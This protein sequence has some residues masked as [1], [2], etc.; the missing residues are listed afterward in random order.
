MSNNTFKESIKAHGLLLVCIFLTM[1][2]L[3]V[4]LLLHYTKSELL[5]LHT[6]WILIAFAP[7]LVAL[8][9]GGYIRKFKGFGIEF[10]A[11]FNRPLSQRDL[12]AAMQNY[13]AIEV[14][15]ATGGLTK[16]LREEIYQLSDEDKR[17]IQRLS[18]RYGSRY[19]ID[20]AGFYFSKLTNLKYI[21]IQ[22]PQGNFYALLPIKS[23]QSND[24]FSLFID[25][26][27]DKQSLEQN[28]GPSFI[29]EFVLHNESV[30][31]ILPKFLESDFEALA[32]LGSENKKVIGV[33]EKCAFLESFV[34]SVVDEKK[35][36]ERSS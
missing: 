12:K 27:E 4:F 22:N 1:L 8:I 6:K 30:E 23:I 9:A 20:T 31:K 14:M 11:I 25:A 13:K 36:K 29:K 2:L 24:D 26:L 5:N 28:F 32:V 16:G 17:K 3:S 33:I 7:L 18:F 35:K 34:N 21:E 10:E 19:S 15:G